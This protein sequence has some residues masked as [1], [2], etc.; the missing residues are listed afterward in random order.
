MAR[1]QAPEPNEFAKLVSAAIR[2]EMGNHRMSGRELARQLGKSE[3]YV[4]ER[5]KDT[6]EWSLNDIEDFCE[7]IGMQ[8]DVFVARI[9]ADEA[10]RA[11]FDGAS[12][13]TPLRQSDS[14]SAIT[15]DADEAIAASD[16]PDY[17]SEQEREQD[18]P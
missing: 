17:Q 18:R 10:F 16:R 13:V 1:H 9:E 6:Y 11:R 8:P 12:N 7:L 15:L 3:G 2:R 4:R 14:S 5:V